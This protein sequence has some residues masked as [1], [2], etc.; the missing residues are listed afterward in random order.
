MHWEGVFATGWR[1]F[2][3]SYRFLPMREWTSISLGE[4][5]WRPEPEIHAKDER[6]HSW[7][8]LLWA[9][10]SSLSSSRNSIRSCQATLH[11]AQECYNILCRSHTLLESE[12]RSISPAIFLTTQIQNTSLIHMLYVRWQSS[13]E[14]WFVCQTKQHLYVMKSVYYAWFF[15]WNYYIRK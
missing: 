1:F 13:L 15:Q 9:R 8:D 2:C 3:M 5:R 4:E 14:L 7:S 12:S 6:A 11:F 10:M